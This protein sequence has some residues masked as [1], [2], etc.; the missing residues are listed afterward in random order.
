[1]AGSIPIACPRCGHVFTTPFEHASLEHVRVAVATCPACGHLPSSGELR[2]AL[3]SAI[4]SAA[5]S[6]SD[7]EAEAPTLC[8]TERADG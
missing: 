8:R 1:M 4:E 7:D 3:A 5:D 6:S 2:T